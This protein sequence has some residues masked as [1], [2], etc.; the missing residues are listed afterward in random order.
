MLEMFTECVSKI[1][2]MYNTLCSS[3]IYEY[4]EVNM[5][6]SKQLDKQTFHLISYDRQTDIKQQ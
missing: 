4:S 1:T 6:V 2:A 5:Q 3:N